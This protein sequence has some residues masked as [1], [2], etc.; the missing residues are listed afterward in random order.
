M[1]TLVWLAIIWAWEETI[2]KLNL[3]YFGKSL[4]HPLNF[5]KLVRLPLKA[6][7]KNHIILQK[8]HKMENPIVLDSK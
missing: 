2:S 5:S 8:N 7:L 6:V 1:A 4:Y 3:N